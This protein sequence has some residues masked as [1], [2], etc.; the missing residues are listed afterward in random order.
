MVYQIQERARERGVS[1]DE[2]LR[3][4]IEQRTKTPAPSNKK[5]FTSQERVHLLREWASSHSTNTPLLSADA[6]NRENI[7]GEHD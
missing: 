6:I 2:Y 4:L 5:Q 7:Y 1:V 3:E